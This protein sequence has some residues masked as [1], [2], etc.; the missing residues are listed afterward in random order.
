VLQKVQ[1]CDPEFRRFAPRR[2]R[3]QRSSI[4]V[5]QLGSQSSAKIQGLL[6]LAKQYGNIGL[7]EKLPFFLK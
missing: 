3:R 4:E 2:G 6:T 1:E 5:L 7:V